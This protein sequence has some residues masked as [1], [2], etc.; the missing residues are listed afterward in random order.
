MLDK[1]YQKN[2]I[3]SRAAETACMPYCLTAAMTAY[4]S[5]ACA[6]TGA[7]LPNWYAAGVW[8]TVGVPAAAMVAAAVMGAVRLLRA[9]RTPARMGIIPP[10][11]IC[12]ILER[13]KNGQKN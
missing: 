7:P 13:G 4:A 2:R 9:A 8:I 6:W 5:Y 3:L 1:V 11:E 12:R 10:D